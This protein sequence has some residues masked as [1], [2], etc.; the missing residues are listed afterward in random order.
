MYD[1]LSCMEQNQ[2]QGTNLRVASTNGVA[3]R[4]FAVFGLIALI[5]IGMWGTVQ[6]ASGVP[7]AFSSL[8]S[9][10]VSLTS[11]FVPANEAVTLSAASM[12]VQSGVP[13]TLSWT[14]TDQTTSGSYTFRYD[15]ANG[16]SFTS[17]TASGT[18]ANIYCN[19]PF[20]F[21]NSNNSISLTPSSTNTS[22]NVAV[23]IDFMPNGASTPTV[24]GKTNMIILGGSTTGTTPTPTQPVTQPT[25]YVARTA[26]PSTTQ[27]FPINASGTGGVSNPNGYVDLAVNVIQ[28]GTVNNATGVFTASSTPSLA[29]LAGGNRIAVEFEIENDGTKT[30][31][32][33]DFDAVL[34]TIPIDIFTS[35]EQP[36]LA[37]GD[38]IDYTLGFDS[39]NS[40]GTGTFVVNADPTNSINESNKNNNIIHYTITTTP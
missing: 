38:R 22:A 2:Q 33:F 14:H 15:C 24:T 32:Q 6:I 4:I 40:S 16:V 26:G 23:Y 36:A 10:F 7:G 35:P 34:P 39:F 9:A 11:V 3:T 25:T 27:T 29:A 20:N 1:N 17:P 21:V 5:G 37:P 31:P 19:I 12:T 28:V 18:N 30:S 13:F 8:A